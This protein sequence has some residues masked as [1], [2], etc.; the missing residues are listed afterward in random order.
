MKCLSWVVFG[1]AFFPALAQAGTCD[2]QGRKAATARGEALVSAYKAFIACDPKQ[3][4]AGF[5]PFMKAAGDVGTLVDLSSAAIGAQLYAPVWSMLEKLPDYSVRSEVAGGIGGRC[6]KQPQV[7]S[8]LER[9]YAELKGIQFGHWS[10]AFQACRQGPF[11]EWLASEASKPPKS[12]FDEKYPS[13]LDAYVGHLG[14][15]ALGVL[16]KAAV[17]AASNG[18]PFA[19]ILE[20]MEKS[21]QTDEFGGAP[22]AQN[23]VRLK[24]ALVEVANGVGPKEAAMVADHLFQMGDEGAAA[25]LLPR[26]YPDRVQSDGH[27]LYGVAAVE[28]CEKEAAIHWFPVNEPAKRWSIVADVEPLARAAKPKLK[29]PVGEPWPVVFAAEPLGST[30]DIAAWADSVAEQWVAK[31]IAA[32]PKE[33]KA[34]VLP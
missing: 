29:C 26:V 21:I 24:A 33:E 6:E 1:F 10:E 11:R 27:L 30:K 2:V 5:E 23:V 31:G 12:A 7:V 8:F 17:S 9:S 16:G 25:G 18:G 3:A 28:V 14:P 4:E 22:S 13:L 15:D 32:K 19:A 34:I 20:R